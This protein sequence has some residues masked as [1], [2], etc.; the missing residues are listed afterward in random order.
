[1][2]AKEARMY[3]ED[4]TSID[5]QKQINYLLN[6]S[7]E[8]LDEIKGFDTKVKSGEWGFEDFY[9]RVMRMFHGSMTEMRIVLNVTEYNNL[10]NLRRDLWAAE[11]EVFAKAYDYAKAIITKKF[12]NPEDLAI[13][14]DKLSK[15]IKYENLDFAQHYIEFAEFKGED[16]ERNRDKILSREF[17]GIAK[18]AIEYCASDCGIQLEVPEL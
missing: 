13:E 7:D 6:L 12:D 2:N 9:I 5:V 3:N 18:Q 4:A 1:M 11:D 14:C 8:I 10:H 16:V 15:R 17:Y